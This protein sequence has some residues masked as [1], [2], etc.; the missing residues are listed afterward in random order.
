[1]LARKRLNMRC[2]AYAPS[3]KDCCKNSAIRGS[4]YCWRHQAKVPLIITFLIGVATSLVLLCW[5]AIF[6]PKMMKDIRENTESIPKIAED[7][8]TIIGVVDSSPNFDQNMWSMLTGI[9]APIF[10]DYHAALDYYES[11]D[12]MNTAKRIGSAISAYESVDKWN[13]K[14]YSVKQH[15]EQV[16]AFYSLAAK[17]NIRL[18]NH[19]LAYEY[20]GKA[21]EVNPTHSTHYYHAVA[22]S[23]MK[24]YEESLENIDKAIELKPSDSYPNVSIYQE[25]KQKCLDHLNSE[26]I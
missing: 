11:R 10:N 14:N 23:N 22:S 4:R 9:P 5:Q 19:S 6:P 13:F 15:K 7:V 21:L 26:K 12:Y 2:Q 1:M 3:T 8:E 17:A 16:S 18:H 24:K 25:I 20:S